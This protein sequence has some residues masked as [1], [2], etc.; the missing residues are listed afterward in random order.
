VPDVSSHSAATEDSSLLGCYA[1]LLLFKDGSA[2][3]LSTCRGDTD[4]KTKKSV[5]HSR[6]GKRFSYSL[7][8]PDRFL[9][10]LASYHMHAT[11]YSLEDK[12]DGVSRWPLTSIR[13][14]LRSECSWP[15]LPRMLSCRC[16]ELNTQTNVSFYISKKITTKKGWTRLWLTG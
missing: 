16:V 7:R 2:F 1:V 15:P 6:Q 4:W 11:G 14:E 9:G 10:P 5:F 13:D 3:M 8:Y 12:D